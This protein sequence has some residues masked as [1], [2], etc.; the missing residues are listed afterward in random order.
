MSKT[1]TIKIKCKHCGHENEVPIWL[2]MNAQTDTEQYTK[3]LTGQLF[4]FECGGCGKQG[5]VN[6]DMV[7]HDS[8]HRVIIHCVL[9]DDAEKMAL[10]SI[11]KMLA[12]TGDEALPADYTIRV[13]RTQNAL[14][15]KAMI[16]S[17]GMDDR[18]MEILKGI[19]ISNIYRDHPEFDIKEAL[20]L[21]ANGKW[22]IQMLTA[23]KPL[24]AEIPMVRYDEIR[25]KMGS[26]IE[27]AEIK[28][29]AVDA[30]WALDVVRAYQDE[31]GIVPQG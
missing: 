14:R 12:K 31:H 28:N 2:S 22:F 25:R 7:Y 17:Y 26:A 3:M 21:S 16:F 6:H 29:Y 5:R 4:T 27:A 13:V 11:E 10:D 9:S 19:S 1:T 23:D 15:E 18:I 8:V 20:F 24:S 30:M